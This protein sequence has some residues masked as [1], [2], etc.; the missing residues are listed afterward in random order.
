MSVHSSGVPT[1]SQY[2]YTILVEGSPT[3]PSHPQRRPVVDGGLTYQKTLLFH[4]DGGRFS[5]SFSTNNYGGPGINNVGLCG[6]A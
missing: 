2:E 6:S 4:G 1:T 3:N 5:P